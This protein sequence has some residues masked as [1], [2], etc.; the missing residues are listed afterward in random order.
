M[1]DFGV[2][3]GLNPAFTLNFHTALCSGRITPSSGCIRSHL[4][5]LGELVASLEARLFFACAMP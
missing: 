4:L 5:R 2:I 1:V 3:F